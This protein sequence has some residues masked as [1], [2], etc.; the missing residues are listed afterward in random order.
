MALG[1]RTNDL[2]RTHGLT[3]GRISQL[4][5]EFHD[6]WL[7]FIDELPTS[8]VQPRVGVA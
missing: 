7:R 4:R 2:A 6:D 8:A 3:P 1:E 5:R